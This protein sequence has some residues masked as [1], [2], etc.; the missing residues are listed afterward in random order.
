MRVCIESG[1]GTLTD[2]TRCPEHTRQR[3]KARGT[4]TDRG[5]GADHQRLRAEYQALMNRGESF[6]CW[7]CDDEI[8]P[9]HWHLGHDDYDRTV[10]RG[11]ECVPCNTATSGR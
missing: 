5:Y 7:R 6:A 3:D 1:C 2:R 8:D 10:Y 11:P 4:S 9:E